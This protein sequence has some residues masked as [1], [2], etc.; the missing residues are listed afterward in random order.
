MIDFL[1]PN[2]KY[3]DE[4]ISF[5]DEFERNGEEC[6]GIANYKDYDSWLYEKENR[7]K[8]QNLLKGYVRENFYICLKEQKLVGVFSLKFELTDFLL[9]YGGHIG[10]AV[11][12]SERNKGLATEML[13]Q[14]LK[15]AE[16]FGMKKV[17]LVCDKSNSASEKVIIKNGGIL[18]NELYDPNEH[19]IVK[20][21]WVKL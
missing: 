9:N 6:I 21:Y 15:L 18:E 1:L 10:Y 12:P 7:F 5:Y 8:G 19:Q 16:N 13:A 20:R 17:L 2:K 3:R 11:R 4:I 14:G